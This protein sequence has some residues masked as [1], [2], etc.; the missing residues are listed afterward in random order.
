MKIKDLKLNDKNEITRFLYKPGWSVEFTEDH[1]G[2]EIRIMHRCQPD[3]STFKTI[4]AYN[5]YERNLLTMEFEKMPIILRST[6]DMSNFKQMKE[7]EFWNYLFEQ[8]RSAE[9]HEIKEW[10]KIDGKYLRNPHPME[11][12]NDGISDSE[13]FIF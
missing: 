3:A 12:G 2:Y 6:I 10:F 11:Y 9:M 13:C 7:I 8:V 5:N 1:H 4:E